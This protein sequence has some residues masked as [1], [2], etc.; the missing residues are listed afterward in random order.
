MEQLNEG[1]D[2]GN[3]NMEDYELMHRHVF[4][5]DDRP[6]ELS[7]MDNYLSELFAN[8]PAE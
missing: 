8:E 2:P 3:D 5:D 1:L 4:V 6:Y 7:Y